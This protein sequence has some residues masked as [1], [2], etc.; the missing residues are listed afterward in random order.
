M[1]TSTV[2]DRGRAKVWTDEELLRI[3]HEGKV[4]LVNG[5]LRLMT[6]A[7]MEQGK[8]SI[9]LSA[10][11]YHHVHKH[12]LGE[13]YDAQTGFR[14]PQGDLRAPDVSFV[15]TER[16]PEGKTPKG[17]G[18][19]PPDLAVEVFAPDETEEAYN[20]KVREYLRWGVRLVWLV[21]PNTQTVIVY[22]PDG[23]RT[24]LKGNQVLSGEE[25]VPGFKCRVRTLFA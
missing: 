13:V 5:E 1:A 23:T 18:H 6:P 14:P 7:G 12:K 16:L 2:A 24:A 20:E 19:F 21:D 4:E 11:L 10:R 17:F 22:R 3:K 8:V 25:V 9:S 15:R